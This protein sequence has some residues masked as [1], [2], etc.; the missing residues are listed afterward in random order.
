MIDWTK[1]STVL[2]DMDGTLL[3]L[4]FDNYFWQEYVPYKYAEKHGIS[5]AKAKEE[6][7]PR[8]EQIY[9]KLQWYCLDYW[10]VELDL[11]IIAMKHE[12]THLISFRP[13]ADG[14]LQNIRDHGK[15]VIMIT[16][17]HRDSL[18][19]KLE[20]LPMAHYFD[21]L[22]SSHDYGYPKEEQSF[23]RAL[24]DDIALDKKHALF[25]DDN[26]GILDS[27]K[28]YGI[29]ELLAIRYPDS[30]KGPWDTGTYNAVEDFRELFIS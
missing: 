9:G 13:Y 2:L 4:H 18:S 8:F 30:Q 20:R 21:K 25:I 29:A 11:D 3:D 6:L 17:A 22:I 12:I 15:Q 27:A 24:E 19:L 1:I 5:L 16:N 7:N 10:A 26:I 23:W 14:F 28:T